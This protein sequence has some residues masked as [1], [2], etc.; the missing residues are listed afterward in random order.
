FIFIIFPPIIDSMISTLYFNGVDF[1]S[2]YLF[3]SPQ[4]LLESYLTF[5]GDK[6]RDGI[7]YGTRAMIA[8]ALASLGLLTYINTKKI[9][10]SLLIIFVAYTIFFLLSALPSL[11]TYAVHDNHLSSNAINVASTIASPTKIL[12]NQITNPISSINIKMSFVYMLLGIFITF[13]MFLKLYKMTFVR[14]VLNT[15]LIQTSYHIGL[16]II[17]ISLST[18]FADAIL[19]PSF[20]SVVAFFLLCFAVVFAWYSTVVFNDLFDKKIDSLSNPNRPLPKNLLS[21]KTYKQIGISLAILS[22]IIVLAV[23][24]YAIFPLLAYHAISFLYNTPPIQLKKFPFIATFTASVASFSILMLG[25]ITTSPEH[26]IESLP[27]NITF[28]LIISFAISLPIKDLK[29]IIGDKADNIYTIPVIFGEKMARILIATNIFTSFALSIFLLGTKNLLFPALLSGA[30]CFWILTGRKKD[31]FAF[32]AN[33]SVAL[34]F[35]ITAIYAL[36]LAISL[37]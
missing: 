16:L 1:M 36:I 30:L 6:P 37:F 18:L 29:D 17:G 3:D 31:G 27:A 2:Y 14:L 25:F 28:L 33:Q 23:S 8:V 12:G 34:V 11:I 5:F 19:F 20:F 22:I 15:R 24:P 10:R 7:T 26:S 21:E 9:S 4:G 35:F 13:F 32:T